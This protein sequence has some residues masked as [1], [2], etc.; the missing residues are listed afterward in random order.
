MP[1]LKQ[2]LA[3][4]DIGPVTV[5]PPTQVEAIT[6]ELRESLDQLKPR[7]RGLAGFSRLDLATTSHPAVTEATAAIH[8][9]MSLLEAAIMALE[10]LAQDGYPGLPDLLVTDT[11]L[12]DLQAQLDSLAAAITGFEPMPEAESVR[13]EESPTQDPS[14][15]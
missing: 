1:R 4:G 10:A 6:A 11:V 8:R 12:A 14:S 3:M 7:A 15:Q 5:I 13:I 2:Q 9:R